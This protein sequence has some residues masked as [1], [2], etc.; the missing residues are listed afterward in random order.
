MKNKI[1]LSQLSKINNFLRNYSVWIIRGFFITLLLLNVF[2]YY[3][4]VYKII[5]TE[6]SSDVERVTLNQDTLNELLDSIEEREDFLSKIEKESHK[7][8]FR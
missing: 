8:P 2:V 4:Y 1:S 3:K 7:D 6:V 5:N